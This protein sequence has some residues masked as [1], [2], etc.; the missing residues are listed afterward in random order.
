MGS[1]F[2]E[3]FTIEIILRNFFYFDIILLGCEISRDLRMSVFFM[4]VKLLK[5]KLDLSYLL[6]KL[7]ESLS[8]CVYQWISLTTL[9]NRVASHMS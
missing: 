9:I 8:F 1:V 4:Q 3:Y 7:K 2:Q 6:V 5:V